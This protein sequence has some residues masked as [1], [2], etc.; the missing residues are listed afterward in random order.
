M[1]RSTRVTVWRGKWRNTEGSKFYVENSRCHKVV[2]RAALR[3]HV[4]I[5]RGDEKVPAIHTS[6]DNYPRRRHKGMDTQ[7]VFVQR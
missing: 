7:N 6:W 2:M 5:Q 1:K 3:G 4:Y